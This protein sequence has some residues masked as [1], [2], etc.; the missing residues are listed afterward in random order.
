[1]VIRLLP[2]RA[3]E[4]GSGLIGGHTAMDKV[5]VTVKVYTILRPSNLEL[6]GTCPSDQGYGRQTQASDA[7][8]IAGSVY[9]C[10]LR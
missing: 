3:K 6:P 4:V 2:A 10:V 8:V 7:R 5:M 1:M 9:F